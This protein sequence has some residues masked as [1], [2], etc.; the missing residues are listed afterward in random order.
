MDWI[1][2]H[3]LC[4]V[5]QVTT[6]LEATAKELADAESVVKQ[7]KA[8]EAANAALNAEVLELRPVRHR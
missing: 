5:Q 6:T 4:R 2:V 1:A 3:F 8:V 7:V